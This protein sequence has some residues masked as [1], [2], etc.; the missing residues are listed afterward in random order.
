MSCNMPGSLGLDAGGFGLED[1]VLGQ[2]ADNQGCMEG[3]KEVDHAEHEAGYSR[4]CS[5]ER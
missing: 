2:R 5:S 1:A 4:A 3:K